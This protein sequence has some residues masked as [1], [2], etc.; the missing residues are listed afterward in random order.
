MWTSTVG[1]G[2]SGRREHVPCPPRPGRAA[3]GGKRARDTV[4][5][6]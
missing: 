4:R 1:G 5:E 2:E 3:A 6:R